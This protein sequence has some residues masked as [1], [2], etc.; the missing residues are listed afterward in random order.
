MWCL[1]WFHPWADGNV[2]TSRI[3]SYVVLMAKTRAVL[4]GARTIPDQIQLDR[5][6]YFAALKAC[7]K[8]YLDKSKMEELLSAILAE[9]LMSYYLEAGGTIPSNADAEKK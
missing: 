8:G 9:Q 1:H 6:G 7:L 3:T 2:R 5:R 4:P